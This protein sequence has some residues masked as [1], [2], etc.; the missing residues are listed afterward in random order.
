MTILN[1]THGELRWN[2]IK[3]AKVLNASINKNR[4]TLQTT[5]IGEMDDT[6][7]Y[8]KRSTSGSATI[9]YKTDDL[10]TTQIMNRILNDSEAPDELAMILRTG[11][12][13][14][15]ISGQVLISSQSESISVGE[16]TSISINFVISG[17]PSATF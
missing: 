9:L 7:A 13:Q 11:Q 3:I 8:G 5:G 12:S 17:K 16:N 15:T 6:F 14:G 4:D 10:A 1:A 2:G